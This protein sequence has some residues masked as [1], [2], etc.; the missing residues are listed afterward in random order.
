M[1]EVLYT[2]NEAR[3]QFLREA[4]PAATI[5]EHLREDTWKI[6]IPS[7]NKLSYITF[8]IDVGTIQRWT[9]PY[10]PTNIKQ[11]TA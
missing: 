1:P 4:I 10:V 3:K 9:E 7:A 5:I 11:K 6:V 8:Q 2:S